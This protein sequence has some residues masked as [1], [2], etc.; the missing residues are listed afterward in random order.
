MPTPIDDL[1]NN[2][3]CTFC[4]PDGFSVTLPQWAH[5]RAALSPPCRARRRASPSAQKTKSRVE[6]TEDGDA[7]RRA[8]G[9]PCP[10]VLLHG[11]LDH[12]V[13]AGCRATAKHSSRPRTSRSARRSSRTPAVTRGASGPNGGRGGA[14]TRVRARQKRPVQCHT[15]RRPLVVARRRR[16]GHPWT[17]VLRDATRGCRAQ[18]EIRLSRWSTR[19]TTACGQRTWWTPS[20]CARSECAKTREACERG[21]AFDPC[22]LTAA[23]SSAID[24]SVVVATAFQTPGASIFG[25]VRPRPRLRPRLPKYKL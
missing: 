14:L 4:A 15:R 20:S 18:R 23:A 24:L 6:A 25:T 10:L 3:E 9:Q 2:G 7:R 13:C 16:L 5:P 1:P 12:I 21:T 8:D 19:S 22:D 11:L 17:G